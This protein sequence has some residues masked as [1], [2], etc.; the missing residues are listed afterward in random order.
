MRAEIQKRILKQA[1]CRITPDVPLAPLT[2]FRI[3][4]PA[5]LLAEPESV[6]Q[7]I[8]LMKLIHEEGMDFFYIGRGSNI[9]VADEGFDGVVVRSIGKM[10]TIEEHEGILTAGTAAKLLLLTTFAA[11][12][13]FSG[14]E[15]LSGIPGS[16]GG[17]LWMNAGAYGGEICDTLID[18][19]VLTPEF[20]IITLQAGEIGFGYRSAPLLQD[21]IVLQSRYR[22]TPGSPDAIFT[23]MRRIWKQ[24]R[25][26]QPL[27]YPSAGS[28]FKR[29][30]GDFAGR[31]IEAVNGKGARVGGA[32]VSEKH[33]G[34]IINYE[35]ATAADVAGLI[36]EIRQ[37]VYHQF[38]IMLENEVRPVGFK[39]DPFEIE[40]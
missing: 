30:P 25:D 34:F 6:D 12:R 14:M 35:H 29:P 23:E 26:K 17:G 31:L 28:I 3:G 9:L 33:A 2:T 18:V 10:E 4:G 19:Q 15:S 21:K 38:G 32:T 5:A 22:L 24:R 37:R 8:D 16:V 20:E 7:L 40:N 36:R 13:G 27:D 1:S 11:H 39:S